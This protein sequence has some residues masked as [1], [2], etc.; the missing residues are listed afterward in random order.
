MLFLNILMYRFLT[1]WFAVCWFAVCW[2][3][4]CWFA[5]CWFAVCC[6]V[7]GSVDRPYRHLQT[8]CGP[9]YGMAPSQEDRSH[10]LAQWGDYHLQFNGAERK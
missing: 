8:C 1:C 4:V 5:V 3:A 10:W 9:M 6:L 7:A 2:F